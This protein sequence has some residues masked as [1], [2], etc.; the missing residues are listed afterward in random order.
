MAL[1]FVRQPD[2]GNKR[3]AINTTSGCLIFSFV[4]NGNSDAWLDLEDRML[5]KPSQQQRDEQGIP[6]TQGTHSSYSHIDRKAVS[7][8][9]GVREELGVGGEGGTA[10]V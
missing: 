6:L 5:S 8:G 2:G 7:E 9:D 3:N 10:S 1:L 4:K